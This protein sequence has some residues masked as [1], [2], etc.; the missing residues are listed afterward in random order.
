MNQLLT[1]H[2]TFKANSGTSM[3]RLKSYTV[4]MTYSVS[5]NRDFNSRNSRSKI[6]SGG[7]NTV[8]T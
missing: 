2:D 8:Q 4:S 7:Q 5:M 1:L 3:T 6:R